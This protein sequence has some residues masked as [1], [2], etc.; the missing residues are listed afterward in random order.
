MVLNVLNNNLP[1][2][3]INKTNLSLI[4]KTSSPKKMTDF[5]PISLCNVIYKFIS[6]TL[7]NKLK[8]LLPL[9]IFKN[10]SAFTPDRLIT[11]NVLVAFKLMHYLNHKLVGKEGYMA[12]KLDMSKAFDRVEW[13][14]IKRVMEKLGF[15]SKW[16][17]LIMQCIT[18]VFYSVLVNGAAY[19]NVIPSRGLRQGNPF[20]PILFL[21][22]V[23]GLLAII[24][25]AARNHLLTSI[26][27]SQNYPNITHLF[28][29]ND[30]ILFCKAKTEECQEFKQIFRRYE[31]ASGQK[32]NTD[33]SSLFSVQTLIRT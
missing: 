25:E 28:F 5:R 32:I 18:F 33:K 17:S 23:E 7:A 3:K 24:H 13:G 15:C 22:C 10:Q 21:L 31:D 6:K 8:N 14:F 20:S 27:I 29:A 19:E 26:S 16:V 30:S 9:I 11:G 2:T 4:P 1:M 12:I